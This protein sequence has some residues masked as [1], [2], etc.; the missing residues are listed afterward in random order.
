MVTCDCC[1]KHVRQAKV[2]A[3][4][5]VCEKCEQKALGYW[6]TLQEALR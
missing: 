6:R 4:I 2:V 3:K 5:I 1:K